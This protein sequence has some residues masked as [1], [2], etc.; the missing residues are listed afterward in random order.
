MAV[1]FSWL[2]HEE[3]IPVDAPSRLAW[4]IAFVVMVLAGGFA[5]L[6]LWPKN[7]PTH[8][9]NFW[10]CLILFPVGVP[11]L[12]VL[13]RYSVYEGRKL[14]I[15]LS[16]EA[17][18]E[19]KTRVFEAASVPL[20]LVGA[21]YRFSADAG[22][23][24]IEGVRTG[25]LKLETREPIARG[26]EPAKGR[27]FVAPEVACLPGGKE[28]D[29]NRHRQLTQWLFTE[30]L[31]ELTAAI[32][33]LP[34]RLD[35]SVHFA[36]SSGLTHQEN[37]TLWQACWRERQLR[38]VRL[39]EAAAQAEDLTMLDA[40]LDQIIEAS[41]QEARLVVAIQLHPLLS[42]PPPVG[43]A[44]AGV[45]L[46]LAPDAQAERFN[47]VRSANLH[48]PVRGSFDQS[49]HALLHAMKWA[50]VAAADIPGGWQT[51]VDAAQYGQWRKP[52]VQ[53]GFTAHPTNLDQ[54]VGYAGVAAPWLAI[55][56]AA[57]SLS[58]T[59]QAQLILAGQAESL[60]CAV[61]RGA[62]A[63]ATYP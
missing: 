37:E 4:M 42:E 9:W 45:A 63:Q 7:I 2:P 14:D 28:D 40:W 56:G 34:R 55:A 29:L 44:E 3:P 60:D 20:A 12:I 50:K 22:Q 32:Q 6:L 15:V 51:G 39:A 41:C 43:A 21:A 53:L 52:A 36:V 61:L 19:Y 33:A 57:A 10:M 46:L 48:R 1:D 23:N 30:L 31:N 59:V 5:V 38:P 62:L 24:A 11:A 13:R 27:W 54:S 8:T 49:S 35:L 18:R 58:E 16:N 17:I 25:A 47:V 26:G